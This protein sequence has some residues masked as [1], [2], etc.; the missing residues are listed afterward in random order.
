MADRPTLGIVGAGKVGQ[1]LARLL[2]DASYRIAAV[3]SP[4]AAHAESLAG[5]VEAVVAVGPEDV[6]AQ[7][8]LTLLTVPDDVIQPLAAL[9][10][11]GIFANLLFA[12]RA[13]KSSLPRTY[14]KYF[15]PLTS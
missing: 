7:A 15:T 11:K 9:A 1:S 10:K 6:L 12:T 2:Y 5:Q 3:F 8:D 14:S 4:T 13:L